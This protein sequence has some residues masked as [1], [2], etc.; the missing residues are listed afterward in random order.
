LR[1]LHL[2]AKAGHDLRLRS[3]SHPGP[4]PHPGESVDIADTTLS[5]A[6]L[7]A[8]LWQVLAD[9]LGTAATATLL[10]R[11]ARGAAPGWPE[12]AELSITR[13]NLEYHYRVP[14]AW[15][16]E[17]GASPAA[18]CALVAELCKLL[19]DLTGSVVVNRLKSI[20]ELRARGVLPAQEGS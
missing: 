3:M 1:N 11:A 12:L 16:G 6:D 18:L 7:F 17:L 19:F 20:P 8:L 15:K 2:E 14:A 10:R 4:P 13:E 9:I 5:A